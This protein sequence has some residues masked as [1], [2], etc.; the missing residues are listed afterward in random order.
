MTRLVRVELRRLFSRRLT[1]LAI[2]A[3][4]VLAGFVVLGT[5]VDAKPPSGVELQQ[6]EQ[7]RQQALQDWKEHGPEMVK[8]CQEEQAKQRETDP[9][10]DFACDQMNPAN[11]DFGMPQPVVQELMPQN[12]QASAYLLSFI[13][14]VLGA[15]F[16]SAEFSTGAIATWLTFEPRRLRVYA[17]KLIAAGVS[18]IPLAI[19]VIAII[20]GGTWVICGA[21]GS[22]ALTSAQRGDL[23]LSGLRVVTLTAV[24]ALVGAAI[25]TLLRHTAAVIGVAMAYVVLVEGVFQGLLQ[26]VQ[27][28]LVIKNVDAWVAHG[29]TYYAEKCRT[30]QDGGYICEAVDKQ[31]SFGHGTLYLAIATMVLV[32]LAGWVFR[33][34]DIS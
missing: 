18:V 26:K 28:W 8:S 22:T 24:A 12:L 31:L 21:W 15:G 25:G 17:S 29:T 23:L 20:A 10:A 4:F 2:L 14:F 19:V 9:T 13:A 27:P 5:A 6:Q 32:L 30:Q 11:A 7:S 1:L 3:A 34:R 33:Q 16:V